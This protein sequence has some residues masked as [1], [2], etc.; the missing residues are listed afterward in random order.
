MLFEDVPVTDEDNTLD[1]LIDG[2]T[3]SIRRSEPGTRIQISVVHDLDATVEGIKNFV[4]K[5]NSVANFINGQFI[6]NPDTGQYGVL[7]GDSSIKLVMRQ[8]QSALVALPKGGERFNTL[9]EIGISTNPKTGTL[10]FNESKVREALTEDYD[11]VANLF[12]RTSRSVGVAEALAQKLKNF[13][14]P[15]FGA[16]KSRIR[17][18]DKIIDGHDKEIERRERQLESKEASIR[19]RF[20]A[21]ET[22]LS[23]LQGQSNFLKARF[24]GG[25]Q[26]AN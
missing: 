24:G 2:V 20:T 13:R 17:A 22:T 21:L 26:K 23:S 11:S 3:L 12:I 9:T 10:D 14:D 19:R 16:M 5:Y 7:S 18:L 8:L 25:G 6:E 1:E 4:D 15:G